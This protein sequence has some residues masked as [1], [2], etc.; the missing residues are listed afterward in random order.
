[1]KYIAFV[2]GGLIFGAFSNDGWGTWVGGVIGFL[3]AWIMSLSGR[4]EQLEQRLM[5]SDAGQRIKTD[6]SEP[7]SQ[8]RAEE[9]ESADETTESDRPGRDDE[10]VPHAA[11]NAKVE[12]I[13]AEAVNLKG[14]FEL[15]SSELESAQP[16]EPVLETVQQQA[17]SDEFSESSES[18]V[19]NESS[20]TN[21]DGAKHMLD[22]YESSEPSA[23]EQALS[24]G[25]AKIKSLVV[26]YFT[27]GNSLVRTGMLVLFIGVAF[28]LKYVAERTVVPVEARYIGVVVGALLLLVLGWRLRHKRPGFALSL[29]GGGV[30]LLYLTL[31][32][33]MRLHQLIPSSVVLLCLIGIVVLSAALAVLQNSMALAVIGVLGGFAAP[34]LTSTGSGSHVQL[35]AY[36]LLLNLSI[37]GIAWFK[38]WRLLNVLGFFATFAVGSMW[39]L[40]YYQPQFFGSVE[41]FLIAHF[42]LYVIIAVLFAFKQPPKL[43]GINDGTLIFGTPIVVFALQAGLVKDMTYGLAYSALVL[44]VFYVLLAMLIKR[45]HRPFFKD[46]IESFV[47]LGVGFATLAIPLG[48]DGRVTSAMWVAEASALVWVGVRQSRLLPRF[49]GYALAALGC[50]A[51]FVESPGRGE[52]LPFL[53]ADFVGVLI[54]VAACAFMGL[55]VK[56]NATRLWSFEATWVPRLMLLSAVLWWLSGSLVELYRHFPA[57]VYLFQQIWLAASVLGMIALGHKIKDGLMTGYALVTNCLM[58]VMMALYM[59]PGDVGMVFFNVRFLGML[60]VALFFLPMSLFWLKYE[61]PEFSQWVSRRLLHRF[62]LAAG[63]LVWLGSMT[64][65]IQ[66]CL[67]YYQL[68]WMMV[69]LAFTAFALFLYGRRNQL[70]DFQVAAVSVVFAM[71][72]PLYVS[73]VTRDWFVPRFIEDGTPL[74]NVT[75]VSLLI[76]AV[77]HFCFSYVWNHYQRHTA[78]KGEARL[79]ISRMLLAL[80]LAAWFINGV[81]EI[82]KFFGL[83]NLLPL[84]L[85]MFVVSVVFFVLLAHR[86]KWSDLHLM[87][88]TVMPVLGL[89]AVLTPMVQNYHEGFGWVAF[90]L[91]FVVN[92][93]VIKLYEKDRM[94]FVPQFHVFSLWILALVFCLETVLLVEGRV[95]ANNIWYL[96]SFPTALLLVCGLV[97]GLRKV[98]NWPLVKHHAAYYKM[99]LPVMMW[100]LWFG[101]L[102]LNLHEPGKSLGVMYLP[103]LNII[104]LMGLGAVLLAVLMHRSDPAC[105]FINPMKHKYIIAAATGFLMLNATMLR[106]FHYWYGIEYKFNDMMGSF[107]VQTGLSIL[108]A[109]AAVTLMVLAAKKQWRMVWLVGLGL[110]IVV[111]AKLFLVDMSASGSIERIVAFLTVGVLLSLVGYFSPLPPDV[112][113]DKSIAE[114]RVHAE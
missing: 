44:G 84:I 82:D 36:Y 27:G 21:S 55:Y 59:G 65:E 42:L 79:M 111:V 93:W 40:Q 63:V 85:S 61:W 92:Y 33:A 38:S 54:V 20:A 101:L 86:L 75:F 32:A 14:E 37:F 18:A 29:Q 109:A 60:V 4:I 112:K 78:G 64:M 106:C 69:L 9:S 98:L 2:I 26:G 97:F 34:I 39:G 62:F 48:F 70:E 76:Y 56:F 6:A 88:Y 89:F 87:K 58:L 12:T 105:F 102:V 107:M 24:N 108:W 23:F 52:L 74:L 72:I 77:T 96:S 16:E 94:R 100:V 3:I 17:E 25:I 19:L 66:L 22:R 99:A 67:S 41:P 104:D 73:L 90:P 30:G 114:E 47:A 11:L 51:F 45:L 13:D 46:L 71:V 31:F 7:E 8:S 103:V 53:N 1:M 83:P 80:S 68:L 49:S 81:M 10:A 95:G 57:H 28:L 35:F 50:A 43:K 5:K 110:M 91:A 113:V 15:A